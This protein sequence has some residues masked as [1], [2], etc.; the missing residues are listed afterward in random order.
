MLCEQRGK[1]RNK[2]NEIQV[3]FIVEQAINVPVMFH[4]HEISLFSYYL[5]N[6]NVPL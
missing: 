5:F 6:I 2:K 1:S 4:G 3:H